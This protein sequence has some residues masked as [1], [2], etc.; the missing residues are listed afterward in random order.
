MN[1]HLCCS[2]PVLVTI[3][4][5]NAVS[6]KA[7]SWPRAEKQSLLHFAWRAAVATAYYDG[8]TEKNLDHFS[9]HALLMHGEYGYSDRLNALVRL[10]VFR[11]L[12]VRE[13]QHSETINVNSPG[14]VDVGLRY[15]FIQRTSNIL[16][17]SLI[18]SLPLGETYNKQGIWT[19][20]GEY[21]QLLLLEYDHRFALLPATVGLHAGFKKKHGGYTDELHFGLRTGMSIGDAITVDVHVRG[22][23]PLNNGDAAF[24]GGIFG[25]A[26]N[27]SRFILYGPEI[28]VRIME[29]IDLT[30]GAYGMSRLANIPSAF[31]ISTGVRV[32]MDTA[33]RIDK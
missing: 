2:L 15:T 13:H 26:A 19:G 4:F 31:V 11:M 14:D 24:K 30:T 8:T 23:E 3:F 6:I 16:R 21:N 17:M 9:D 18:V 20:T 12:S 25:F 29:G 27:K 5:L 7:D 28:A 33:R 32:A 10:P 1:M 22:V